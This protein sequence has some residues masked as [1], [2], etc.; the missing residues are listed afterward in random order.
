MGQYH[1][2]QRFRSRRTAG[3]KPRYRTEAIPREWFICKDLLR[4][5]DAIRK[6]AAYYD[7]T[8]EPVQTRGV[9]S[10]RL[11]FR[12]RETRFLALDWRATDPI[13]TIRDA[14]E[15]AAVSIP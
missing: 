3:N 10:L 5:L 11:L 12:D 14:I 1:K 2:R 15:I 4:D 7:M 9:V 13:I 6:A 8:V